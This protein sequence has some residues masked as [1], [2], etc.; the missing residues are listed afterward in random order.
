MI[1]KPQPE[2][3]GFDRLETQLVRDAV[4]TVGELYIEEIA[5]QGII[6]YPND[7][8]KRN[9][10]ISG[11]WAFA[12]QFELY[13]MMTKSN[14]T[15]V[16]KTI[17]EHRDLSSIVLNT[18]VKLRG[19]YGRNDWEDLLTNLGDGMAILQPGPDTVMDETATSTVRGAKIDNLLRDNLWAVTIVL[20]SYLPL[21]TMP[22]TLQAI[23]RT[24]ASAQTT[25]AVS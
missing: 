21:T 22:S 12:T 7:Q 17:R 11:A 1:E 10:L 13:Q 5:R 18:T 8:A 9:G 24:T 20:L 16:W 3:T 6:Y 4:R 15:E 25:G 19:M 2:P 23:M 14:L